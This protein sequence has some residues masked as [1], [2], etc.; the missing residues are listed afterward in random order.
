MLAPVARGMLRVR[1]F[2][3]VPAG[4]VTV[5]L[6]PAA[7]GTTVAPLMPGT[8]G[9]DWMGLTVGWGAGVSASFFPQDSTRAVNTKSSRRVDL[10]REFMGVK[11]RGVPGLKCQKPSCYALPRSRKAFGK[12]IQQSETGQGFSGSF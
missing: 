4:T 9:V 10:R 1:D 3:F 11:L 12:A 7:S 6:V 2:T 8:V 5:K